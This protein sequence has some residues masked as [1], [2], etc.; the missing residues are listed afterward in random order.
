MKKKIFASSA[1][2]AIIAG[3]LLVGCGGGGDDGGVDIIDIIDV[4]GDD[5]TLQP[6]DANITGTGLACDVSFTDFPDENASDFNAS[7][8]LKRNVSSNGIDD[9]NRENPTSSNTIKRLGAVIDPIRANGDPVEAGQTHPILLSYLQQVKGD[10]E[11]GDGS[12]DIADPT[13]VDGVFSALSL[14]NGETWKNYTISDSSDKNSTTVT[15]AGQTIPYPGHAQKPTMAINGNNI[16]IAWND[17]YC[18]IGNPHN[19]EGNSV[20]GY[21]MDYFA[22]NGNQGSIDYEGI[23]APNE[24]FVYEVPF[25]CVWTARGI[26]SPEDG[27]ITWH[28]PMQLTS[29]KR[30]SNHIKLA[31]A[32]VGFAIAWQE[33]VVGLVSGK[34]AGPGVGWSGATTNRGSDIWYTSIKMEDFNDTNDSVA[35]VKPK[36]LHNFHYPVRITDNEVCSTDD[37]KLYCKP[38][39]DTYGYE[40]TIT[41]NN[42]AT[43][44]NR[45]K[46]YDI[47]MLENTTAVLDGDTGASRPALTILKTD[48]NESVVIFGYEETKG[49]LEED[50][51]NQETLIEFEGKAVYFESFHFDALDDFNASDPSTIVNVSMPLVSAGNIVNVKVPAQED[52]DHMI[53]QNARR[54]IIGT[55]VDSCDAQNPEDIKFAFM[56]KDSHDTQGASSDMFVR[57]N[58]GF[59]YDSFTT[60]NDGYGRDLNVTNVTAQEAQPDVNSTSYVVDWNSSHLVA[61]TY[62]NDLENTFSPR[63]IIRGNDIHTGCA[64][65]PSDAKTIAGHMPS[66]FH[67][68]RYIDGQ[69]KGPQNVTQ[70]TKADV[71]TVDPRFNTT[72][73]GSDTGLD[74]DKSNPDVFF[75]TWGIIEGPIDDRIES[76]IYLKR[77]TDKGETWDENAT[78]IADQDS[79]TTI[80]ELAAQ[81]LITPDG[82]TAYTVWLQEVE[83][84]TYLSDPEF[85]FYGLD[86]WFG[87]L[88]YNISTVPAP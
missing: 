15:W 58:N 9:L 79:G 4:P 8:V 50:T 87:R 66:N 5:P 23:E 2:I 83:H 20:D 65:T 21:P 19:L 42:A 60:L 78:K 1:V 3:T 40:S 85:L 55:Q 28:S 88:D 56:Y 48:A 73:K 57:V 63:I 84:D 51:T 61:N 44:I 43:A 17:K 14:D 12:A 24:K 67:T 80:H 75:V 39:C 62:D 54:L 82:R 68:N 31:A 76:G 53:Y 64:Y 30:D 41:N 18:P 72:P 36:S 26:F 13:H 71:S 46:T 49:L 38:L 32:S 37:N 70:I 52:P 16:L 59:T 35:D 27:N 81:S 47:D 86:T 45:C 69:W 10:Y 33:D 7:Q 74:S 6:P 11:L 77:S 22:V 29:G 25:S 34:G